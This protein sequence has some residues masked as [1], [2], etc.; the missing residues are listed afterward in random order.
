LAIEE[1]K[2]PRGLG[3]HGRRL[4]RSVAGELAD[5]CL[6]MTA[7]ERVWLGSACQMTD[8]AAILEKALAGAARMVRGSMGQDVAN[9]LISE[10]RQLH[11]AVN[12]TLSRIKTDVPEAPGIGIVGLNQHRRAIDQRWRPGRGA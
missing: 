12:L 6:Q 3:V 11:L 5:D 9:P 10:L 2:P 4:W 8:Q 7:I 1:A